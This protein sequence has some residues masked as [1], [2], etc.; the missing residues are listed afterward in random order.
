MFEDKGS[1]MKRRGRRNEKSAGNA[2]R[3]D[4]SM[5]HADIK[6]EETALAMLTPKLVFGI[7]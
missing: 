1:R 7:K 5:A 3:L 2:V 4:V 6:E